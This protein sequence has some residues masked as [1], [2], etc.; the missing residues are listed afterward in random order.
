VYEIAK[1]LGV[2]SKRV[3]ACLVDA[4][5]FVRS[6]STTLSPDD[7]RLVREKFGKPRTA[8]APTTIP[9]WLAPSASK[10]PRDEVAAD[11]AALFGPAAAASVRRRSSSPANGTQPRRRPSRPGPQLPLPAGNPATAADRRAGARE[12]KSIEEWSMR[13]IDPIERRAWL[14]A[15]LGESD[16]GLVEHCLSYGLTPAHL[17]IRVDG[18]RAG[19]RIRGGESVGSVVA[20]LR[21]G[22]HIAS[23]G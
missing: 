16:V 7:V 23:T 9:A 20:R 2:D 19:D 22:E 6:A 14:D 12:Q 5:R 8:A 18:I 17:A 1:E 15:G 3:V 11:A 10:D 21:E 4:G 13:M